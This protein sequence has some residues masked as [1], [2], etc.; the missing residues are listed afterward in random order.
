MIIVLDVSQKQKECVYSL[1]GNRREAAGAGSLLGLID[2]ILKEYKTVPSEVEGIVVVLGQ[3]RFT[4]SRTAV[5]LANCFAYIYGIRLCVC[6]VE[7]LMDEKV[8]KEKLLMHSSK[9][10]LASY[11]A[12]PN[13]TKAKV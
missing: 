13:I 9:Y 6:G 4:S 12:E 5:I 8:V 10:V 3:G 1:G 11:Y 7:D 2:E